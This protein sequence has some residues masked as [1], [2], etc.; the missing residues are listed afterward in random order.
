MGLFDRFRKP[1]KVKSPE[2]RREESNAKIKS[3][4]IA[5]YE[6]LPVIESASEARL[7]SVDEICTR[8][9]AC[10][11]ATQVA[12][13]TNGDDYQGSIEYFTKVMKEFGVYESLNGKEQHLL[14]GMYDEQEAIDVSWTYE[15][16]WSLVWALGLIDDIS[17]ASNLSD[18]RT[19][20]RLVGDCKTFEEFKSRCELRNVEEILDM[21]DLYYRYHWAVTDHR[22]HPEISIGNLNPGVVVERRRG[23]EWLFSEGDMDWFEIALNT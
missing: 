11:L 21:L 6:Q 2:Q 10:L 3:M 13:D 9:I 17:D 22:L 16:Y 19:A 4:G 14:D 5:C 18:A 15:A 23:L 12:C 8:A 20:I 1:A 7:R